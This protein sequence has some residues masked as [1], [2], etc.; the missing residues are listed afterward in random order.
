MALPQQL[1]VS[2]ARIL[3]SDLGNTIPT[4]LGNLES[5]LCDIFGFTANTNITASAMTFDNSGNITK[6][7]VQHSAAGPVGWRFRNTDNNK[8][9][10][11]VVNGTNLDF[12]QNDDGAGGTEAIPVW[13]N[14]FRIALATGALTGTTFSSARSGLAPASDGSASKYLNGAGSYTVPAAPTPTSCRIR[15]STTQSIPTSTFTALTFDTEDWDTGS[16]HAGGNPTR[17]TFP[18][19]GKYLVTGEVIMQVTTGACSLDIWQNSSGGTTVVGRGY[20]LAS[21]SVNACPNVTALVNA[22]AND[23]VELLV[24]QNSGS[25]APTFQANSYSPVFSAYKIGG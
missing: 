8:E 4:K 24:W 1:K 19:A 13:V 7:L 22:A 21:G 23:Y 16:M 25:S 2:P 6:A 14:R 3:S 12:D 20:A 5:A 10:R 15:H 17:I 18:T 11:I 9:M